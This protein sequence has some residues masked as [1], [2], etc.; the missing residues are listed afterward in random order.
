MNY[1]GVCRAGPAT[2]GLLIIGRPDWLPTGGQQAW[3]LPPTLNRQ[4][5]WI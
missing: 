4:F 2:P 5:F 1:K 3:N